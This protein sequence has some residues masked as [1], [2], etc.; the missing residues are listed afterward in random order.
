M[1]RTRYVVA[2][3]IL[4]GTKILGRTVTPGHELWLTEGEARALVNAGMVKCPAVAQIPPADDVSGAI[5]QVMAEMRE[6]GERRIGEAVGVTFEVNGGHG[7]AP[8]GE[9][10]AIHPLDHDADGRK[11][12]S[13]PKSKRRR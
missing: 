1:N 9:A 10:V 2:D 11:G 8:L 12:G 6:L 13:L 3:G 4:R 5:G 7:W